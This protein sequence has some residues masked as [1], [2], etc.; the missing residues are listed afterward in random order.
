[1]TTDLHVATTGSDRAD[2]SADRPLRT[3]NH[4]AQ[5]AQPGDTVIVHAG[6]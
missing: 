2:G 1:L 3:V 5:L 6:E 4:A